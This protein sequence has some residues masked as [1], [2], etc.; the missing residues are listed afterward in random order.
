VG[1]LPD[2][3]DPI[4]EW[5]KCLTDIVYFSAEPRGDGTL[6]ESRL[7]PD[8]WE[9]LMQM[10]E[11]YGTRVHLSIGGW[12]RS[13][14]FARVAA[15]PSLRR[16]FVNQV[17]ESSVRRQ[18]DGVDFDWEFPEGRAQFEGYIRL[19]NEVRSV[20]APRG[21]SVSVALSADTTG[22]L[23]SFQIADRIHIMSYDRGLLHATYNQAVEDLNSFASNELDPHKLILGIPFYGRLIAAPYTPYT[24]GEIMA[25]YSP[26]PD[27]DQVEGIYF[28]GMATIEHKTCY[29]REHGYGGMMIWELGQDTQDETSLL[30]A[31]HAAATGGCA[32]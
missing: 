16:V 28:N 30:R 18:L 1:Y 10:R 20:L 12:E 14:G 4:L 32:P 8:T 2:Y 9:G 19:L 24:Y 26:A 25:R 31:A 22:D 6:D 29:I 3:R 7:N 13:E 21:I 17:L 23:K 5:G 27:Q 11:T 15:S